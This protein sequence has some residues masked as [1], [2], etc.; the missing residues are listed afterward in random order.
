MKI[1]S[2]T[3]LVAG[4]LGLLYQVYLI[5]LND[6]LPEH[7]GFFET[8]FALFVIGLGLYN[9]IEFKGSQESSVSS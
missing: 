6:G 3:W 9:G 8:Y 5:V 7:V 1:K 2:V 4:V